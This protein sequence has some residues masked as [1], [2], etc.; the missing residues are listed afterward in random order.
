MD[1]KRLVA[2]VAVQQS[3][4]EATIQVLQCCYSSVTPLWPVL[5]TVRYLKCLLYHISEVLLYMCCLCNYYNIVITK[6]ITI[7]VQTSIV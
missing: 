7:I 1:K 6:K 2:E 5:V 4:D 3:K